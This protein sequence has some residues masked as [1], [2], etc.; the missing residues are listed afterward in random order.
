MPWQTKAFRNPRQYAEA[1]NDDLLQMC[2]G[3]L[4]TCAR[5]RPA[6]PLLLI[7]LT[8]ASD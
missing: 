7:M 3:R 8:P 5:L 2:Q 4:S 1:A 6:A